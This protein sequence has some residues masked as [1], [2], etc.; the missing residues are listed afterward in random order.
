[1]Q[2]D[3]TCSNYHPCI[4][5]CPV[6][7]CD[8]LMHP[9]KNERLCNTDVCVEGCKLKECPDGTV[10]KNSSYSECVPKSVCKPV[11]L[12]DNGITYYEGDVM[13]SDSCHSCKCTRG[14]KVCTGIPCATVTGP[15]NVSLR[16]LI[17]FH[18]ISGIGIRYRYKNIEASDS[19]YLNQVSI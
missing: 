11:C 2:C 1:M 13:A 15:P 19:R 4:S 5:S 14:S 8:N 3:P 10:Y 7:T 9:Q 16:I 12:E 17:R 6:D 18:L